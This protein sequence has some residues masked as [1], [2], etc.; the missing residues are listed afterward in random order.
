MKILRNNSILEFFKKSYPF[1]TFQKYKDKNSFLLFFLEK[2]QIILFLKDG[3]N[4]KRKIKKTQMILFLFTSEKKLM[5]PP[6]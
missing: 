1:L 3:E 6:F 5:K 2:N 4:G